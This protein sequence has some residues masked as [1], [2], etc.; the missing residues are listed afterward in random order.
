MS[1]KGSIA[2][3]RTYCTSRGW[4]H[5]NLKGSDQS[6]VWNS[7]CKCMANF[8]LTPDL[9]WGQSEWYR[10]SEWPV[11]GSNETRCEMWPPLL[12]GLDHISS[13]FIIAIYFILGD[14]VH[15][16]T[17][18]PWIC[19]TPDH[20]RDDRATHKHMHTCT[21]D[22]HQPRSYHFQILIRNSNSNWE[23]SSIRESK[24]R[25][26]CTIRIRAMR[27]CKQCRHNASHRRKQ[28]K[29]QK[30]INSIR[31]KSVEGKSSFQD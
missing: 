15:Q 8:R 22:P 4:D 10:P 27:S 26:S 6:Q 19:W 21:Q 16:D 24:R 20:P 14:S 12:P 30:M 11:H 1:E 31:F 9:A 5:Q 29:S 28:D 23:R 2:E 25:T 3:G 17:G 13:W 7:P 18:L